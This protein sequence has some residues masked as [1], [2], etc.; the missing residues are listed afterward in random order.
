MILAIAGVLN[1]SNKLRQLGAAD[2]ENAS[3]SQ[4]QSQ[5]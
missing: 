4:P 2:L 1:A 5:L 3:L